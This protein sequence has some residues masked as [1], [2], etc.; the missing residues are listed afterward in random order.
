MRKSFVLGLGTLLAGTVAAHAQFLVVRS[1]GPSA[2]RYATG[3]TIPANAVLALK[4]GDEVV[5]LDGKGTRSL[6]GPGNVPASGPSQATGLAD[7][8]TSLTRQ[9]GRGMA[10]I[11]AVRGSVTSAIPSLYAIDVDGDG[12]YCVVNPSDVTLYRADSSGTRSVTLTRA[13]D[14]RSATVNFAAGQSSVPWPAALAP[15]SA[16]VEVTAASNGQAHVLSIKPVAQPATLSDLTQNLAAN[17]CAR[18]LGFLRRAAGS[19]EGASG[20]Q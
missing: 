8:L 11:G 1:A 15:G 19:A 5:V 18:Q 16:P 12:S 20:A 14:N 7:S 17:A 13:S 2:G 4:P 10:R 9:T 6:K 3:T